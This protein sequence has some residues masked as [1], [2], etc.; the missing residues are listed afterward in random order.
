LVVN[1]EDIV[2]TIARTILEKSGYVVHEACNGREG[3]T[4]C[5]THQGSLDLLLSDVVMPVLGGRELAES[6]LKLRPALKVMLM[7]GHT[8]GVVF[9]EGEQNGFA[10]LQKPFTPVGLAQ[11][12]RETLCA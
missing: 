2:R 12:V 11:K 10:F 3:L 9:K 8:P 4:F 5:E 7:S 6:A 1:D